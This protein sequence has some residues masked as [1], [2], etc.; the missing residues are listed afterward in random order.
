M[1]NVIS[2]AIPFYNTSQYFLECIQY[3]LENEF[4][5]EIVVNDDCSDKDQWKKLNQIVDTLNTNKI[6]LFRNKKNLGPFRNKYTTVLK[7]SNTWVYLLDSDN[8]V[9]ENSYD[10]IKSISN[11][12]PLIIYSPQ[13][14]CCKND[15]SENYEVIS[16]YNFKYDL[17]GIEETKD[18]IF[19]KTKWFDWF[20]NSGNYVLNKDTYIKA[21]KKPYKDKS[22][23]L[24]DAD[25]AAAFYFLL[26]YGVKFKI[27]KN[28]SHYHRLRKD[29]A[30]ITCGEN[31][32]LSV[33][34]YKN[35]SI[36][37]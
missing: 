26:E 19:K 9:F 18:M 30:W 23:P 34:Y 20:F 33:N 4:V 2:L 32:Q 6:K 15:D 17:I 1:I 13:H 14:L 5:S 16:D 27:I 31:S 35:L 28:F 11:V 12:D 37:L 7:C 36:E 22:T 8:H 21:L 10:F 24:L 3:A 29:S 25:T